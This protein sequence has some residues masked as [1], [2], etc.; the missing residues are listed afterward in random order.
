MH[1]RVH[2]LCIEMST[3]FKARLPSSALGFS[4]WYTGFWTLGFGLWVFRTNF[5]F[6]GWAVLPTNEFQR[7]NSCF[8]SRYPFSISVLVTE[9]TATVTRSV[10]NE[11]Y[12]A[13]TPKPKDQSQKTKKTKTQRPNPKTEIH[14]NLDFGLRA[15]VF[16]LWASVLD[17]GIWA[18]MRDQKISDFWNLACLW[19]EN[20]M[21]YDRSENPF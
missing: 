20:Q 4:N 8:C 17:F 5:G 2:Y 21:F 7:T 19:S 18:T 11:Y 9:M 1:W 12:Q 15:S 14:I 10:L 13:R 3:K 16:G 6:C